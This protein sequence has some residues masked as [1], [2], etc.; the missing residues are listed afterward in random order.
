VRGCFCCECCVL[1]GRG[2]CDELITRP[3]ESYRLW[4][5]D[6]CDLETSRMWRSWPALGKSAKAKKKVCMYLSSCFSVSFPIH[7]SIYLSTYHFLPCFISFR[8][9][10]YFTTFSVGCTQ[11]SFSLLF[12]VFLLGRRKLKVSPK[13]L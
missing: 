13:Y 9:N 3:E 8:M 7:Q 11:L 2:P 10:F 4:C 1:S 12:G 5:V 6:V